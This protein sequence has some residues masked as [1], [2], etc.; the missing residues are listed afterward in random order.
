MIDRFPTIRPSGSVALASNRYGP[1]KASFADGTPAFADASA[2]VQR[3]SRR[4]SVSLFVPSKVP[5]LASHRQLKSFDEQFSLK[6]FRESCARIDYRLPGDRI[7]GVLFKFFHPRSDCRQFLRGNA[8]EFPCDL[9][10]VDLEED[11]AQFLSRAGK[12]LRGW[13]DQA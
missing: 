13:K 2:G 12:H 5:L 1:A 8:R 4:V 10:G 7:P 11:K 9:W 6:F 3:T